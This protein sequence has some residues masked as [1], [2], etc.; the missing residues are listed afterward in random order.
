[1]DHSQQQIITVSQLVDITY[2]KMKELGY[3]EGSL[4][5]FAYSFKLFKTYTVTNEVEH[6]T[7]KLAL[8]FLEEYC[9]IFSKPNE[10]S[11]CYQERKRAVAKLDE[12][13]KYNIISS[14]KLFSRKKYIFKG[15]LK[16]SIDLYILHS[17]N[18]T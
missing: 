4:K 15:C 16:N 13:Y 6:Y 9:K 18:N 12:M 7:E 8:A 2:N 11:Y 3:S 1:V 14:K 10:N 5:K 17:L